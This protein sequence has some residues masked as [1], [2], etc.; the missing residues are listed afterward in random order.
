MNLLHLSLVT[1]DKLIPFYRVKKKT[2]FR[3]VEGDP[4]GTMDLRYF[5]KL[6]STKFIDNTRHMEINF[7]TSPELQK[8]LCSIGKERLHELDQ[9]LLRG[10]N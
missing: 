1:R 4:S 10:R 3:I 2:W 5:R 7:K 8:M 6:N 9:I